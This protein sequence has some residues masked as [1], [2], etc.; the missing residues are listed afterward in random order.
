MT[1]AGMPVTV[2]LATSST[3]GSTP[4]DGVDAST[5]SMTGVSHRSL[6]AIGYSAG[7]FE[8]LLFPCA[9]D[10]PTPSSSSRARLIPQSGFTTTA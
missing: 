9:F 10:N 2:T 8:L 4:L 1:H 7:R 5:P 6:R 3:V